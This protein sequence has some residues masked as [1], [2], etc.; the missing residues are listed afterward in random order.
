MCRHLCLMLPSNHIVKDSN[1]TKSDDQGQM[2][3]MGSRHA[4]ISIDKKHPSP[5]PNLR[6]GL[7]TCVLERPGLEFGKS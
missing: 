7:Y 1:W 2:N 5:F 6:P 4:N 3:P